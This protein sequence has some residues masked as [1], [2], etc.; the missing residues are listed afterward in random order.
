[1]PEPNALAYF[2]AAASTE[3]KDFG[4][5]ISG[6]RD[7]DGKASLHSGEIL[8]GRH[9]DAHPADALQRPGEQDVPD[10]GFNLAP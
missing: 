8:R 6:F 5:L 9:E 1:M 4:T 10:S 3:T 7:F 2:A